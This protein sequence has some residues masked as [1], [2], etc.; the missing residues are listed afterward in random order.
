[1]KRVLAILFFVCAFCGA[2]QARK[3]EGRVHYSTWMLPGVIVTDG[4]NFTRTNADGTFTLDIKADAVYIYV[5]TPP[6]YTAPYPDGIPQFWQ[7]VEGRHWF[8]FELEPTS[9]AEDYTILAFNNPQITDSELFYEYAANEIP[10]LVN[11]A[12]FARIKGL[13][14]G[15]VLGIDSRSKAIKSHLPKVKKELAKLKIPLYLV[16]GEGPDNQAFC[17]GKDLVIGVKDWGL[18]AMAFIKGLMSITPEYTNVLLAWPGPTESLDGLE[19]FKKDRSITLIRER[20]VA[21]RGC[22]VYTKRGDSL[23]WLYHS[24]E[25]G[26]DYQ[27]ELIRP[28]EDWFNPNELLAKIWDYDSKWKV[29]WSQDG[30]PMGPMSVLRPGVL[31]AKPSRYAKRASIQVESRFGKKWVLETDLHYTDIQASCIYKDKTVSAFESEASPTFGFNSIEMGLQLSKDGRVVVLQDAY[32]RY[33][34]LGDIEIGALIDNVENR[35]ALEREYRVTPIHYT[36]AINSGSGAGEGK[37]WP[38]YREFADR[39]LE[40]LLSKNLGDRLLIES[41][42]DRVL[43]Y[44][45]KK[46][47]QVELCYLVDTECGSFKDYM[48]LLDFTPRWLGVQYEMFDEALLRQARE[49]GM[50]VAVWDVTDVEYIKQLL[51]MGVDSII[52]EAA[53]NALEAKIAFDSEND[54]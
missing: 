28:G 27:V 47:P 10:D 37:V 2:L 53:E 6:G 13:T 8:D 20:P 33:T 30:V 40:V 43:N 50:L 9:A 15:L 1:M 22:E 11:Q 12:T 46:Y 44:I 4:S 48:S 29:T 39:C 54:N 25:K 49:A 16:P 3:V 24:T 7:E 51:K 35:V 38:E 41:F 42:D 19:S 36:F 26:D 14:T 45:H 31:S 32:P 23:S 34:N 21:P 5:V 17:I 52:T 18:D